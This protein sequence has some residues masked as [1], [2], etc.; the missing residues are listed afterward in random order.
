[1]EY[2]KLV[3]DNIPDIIK[4]KG[5]VAVTHVAN[6]TEYAQ[7]L[8]EKLEE[9]VAEYLHDESISEIADILEVIDAIAEYKGFEYKEIVAVKQE[10]AEKR[11]RF[12]KRIILDES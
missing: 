6:D 12:A 10:K 7:K 2:H 11:G 1:M 4:A 9:E 8:R 3:R 5:E